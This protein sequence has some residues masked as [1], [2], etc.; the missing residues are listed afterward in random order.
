MALGT[1]VRWCYVS[2]ILT[3]TSFS[4]YK[5]LLSPFLLIKFYHSE[6]LGNVSYDVYVRISNF[7]KFRSF[8]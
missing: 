8:P 5:F 7:P 4:W 1:F 3:L 2:S 6:V